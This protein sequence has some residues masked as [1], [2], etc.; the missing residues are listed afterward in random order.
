MALESLTHFF[1]HQICTTVDSFPTRV[2]LEENGVA[3][4]GSLQTFPE[5]GEPL[6]V[7]TL[8]ALR[9]DRDKPGGISNT[10]IV[11]SSI[12]VSQDG[13]DLSFQLRTAIDVQKP[14][15]LFEQ[16]G[17][18][19]LFRITAAKASL[20]S[21]DGNMLAI[22]ASALEQDWQ[23]PDGAALQQSVLSFQAMDRSTVNA[24][25]S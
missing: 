13:L 18:T 12:V 6:T 21:K 24:A 8:I 2:L 23:G 5:L 17:I 10:K 4:T 19:E 9:R 16:Y 22:F 7:A 25:T 11:P 15:L 14:E 1:P 20:R 3:A